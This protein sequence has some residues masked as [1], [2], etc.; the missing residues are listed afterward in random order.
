MSIRLSRPDATFILTKEYVKSLA[1]CK[2]KEL[3]EEHKI[4]K[5]YREGVFVD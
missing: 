2:Q 4:E 5:M 3:R 1:F